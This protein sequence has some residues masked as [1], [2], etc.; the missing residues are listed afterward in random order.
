[1]ADSLIEADRVRELHRQSGAERWS[2]SEEVL[3]EAIERSVASRFRDA[4]GS[5]GEIARYLD[6]LQIA[7]LALACGCACGD[8]RAW[9]HF[10]REFRPL[11]YRVADAL[12]P[13]GPGR[14]IADSLYADLY[15]LEER[16]GQRRS[17]FGYFHGRS[18]L[19]T[20]LRSVVAQRVVDRSREL[21]RLEP[22]PGHDEAVPA[23]STGVAAPA[24]PDRARLVGAVQRALSSALAGLEPRAR[25]RLALYY[26]QDLTLSEIGRALGESEATASRKLA[27]A[28]KAI[29]EDVERRL[30]HDARLSA[31]EVVL[32]FEHA[33]SDWGFD[34]R[35]A[36]PVPPSQGIGRRSFQ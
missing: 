6:S 20:W 1:M 17:L 29:R 36:L 22:L 18:T 15:G 21:R 24:D 31:Q 4:Q 11:L 32:A 34:L 23:L 33:L 25:L 9:D 2:V 16:G 27:G 8:E 14:E 28:R 35:Q 12:A 5:R 10:I 26:T 3:R 19:A 7:D 13:G 30:R